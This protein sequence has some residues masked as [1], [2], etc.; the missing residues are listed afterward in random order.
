MKQANPNGFFVRNRNQTRSTERKIGIFGRRLT[1]KGE[2]KQKTDS[3]KIS[4]RKVS[5]IQPVLLGK[6]VENNKPPF[7]NKTTA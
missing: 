7:Q 1:W 6:Q 2:I 3:R 4:N 5:T